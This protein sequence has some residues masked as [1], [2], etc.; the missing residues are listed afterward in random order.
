MH[1][2]A[3]C[4][5]IFHTLRRLNLDN[6]Q[7]LLALVPEQTN[8]GFICVYRI[9]VTHYP[10]ISLY[11]SDRN[12]SLYLIFFRLRRNK[13]HIQYRRIKTLRQLSFF[14]MRENLN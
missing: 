12:T 5:I 11:F 6:D 10:L 3:T 13:L 8:L 4:T 14:H 2:R 7:F 1:H 9:L